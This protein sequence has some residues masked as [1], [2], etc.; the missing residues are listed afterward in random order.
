MLKKILVIT[1]VVVVMAFF[2]NAADKEELLCGFEDEGDIDVWETSES[3][4]SLDSKNVTQGKGCIRWEVSAKEK[5]KDSG[6]FICVQGKKLVSLMTTD[7]SKSKSVK[8]DAY[9]DGDFGA[10]VIWRFKAEDVNSKKAYEKHFTLP[11]KKK[12]TLEIPISDLKTKIDVSQIIMIKL[13][14]WEP[15]GEYKIYFDNLRLS[16]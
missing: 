2:V 15:E 10:D 6:P 5:K 8:I 16:K 9:N 7:W 14:M 3:T 13:Y 4:V 11:R 1:G 12:I